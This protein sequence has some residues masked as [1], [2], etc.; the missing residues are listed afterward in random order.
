M[1]SPRY[2]ADFMVSKTS[3]TNSADSFLEYPV[4]PMILLSN[5]RF[6]HF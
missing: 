6:G 5:V 2:K 3:S 1:F 4:V